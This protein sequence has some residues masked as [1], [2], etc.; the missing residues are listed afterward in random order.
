MQ[1]IS[2]F[3]RYLSCNMN[4]V[5]S[6][7]WG[8]WVSVSIIMFFSPFTLGAYIDAVGGAGVGFFLSFW[9]IKEEREKHNI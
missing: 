2:N 4:M 7:L 9:W 8:L 3:R 1:R 6:M 5:E